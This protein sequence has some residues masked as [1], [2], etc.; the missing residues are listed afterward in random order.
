VRST[1]RDELTTLA[2]VVE[3]M[4]EDQDVFYTMS[5]PSLEV[6]EKSPHLETFRKRG[7]EVLLF[8]DPVDEVWL[9]Q[10]PPEY[11]GKGWQ[12]VGKGDVQLPGGDD[13]HAAEDEARR[14]EQQSE[15]RDLLVRI[16]SALQD[17]VKEVR[18][19][20]RLVD[21]PACLV[22]DEGELSAPMVEMLKQAGQDV[23]P[24][25]PI[26]E[27]NPDHEILARLRG[28]A[29]AD[30]D[31]PRIARA[32]VVLLGMAHLAEGGRP[33]DPAAFGRELAGLLGE[34]LARDG[35]AAHG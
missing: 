5:G 9:E 23:K 29:E 1:A 7:V 28:V 2:E 11:R 4:S 8:T 31:D 19:S 27:V 21:S 32:A 6:L 12:S 24:P 17:E 10:H 16:R 14:E 34:A 22:L 3:R 13:G 33:S 35:G 18:L 15:F 20:G 30:A 25:K 26:L